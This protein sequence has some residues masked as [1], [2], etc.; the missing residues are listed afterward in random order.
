[1][2]GIWFATN[3]VSAVLPTE[4]ASQTT[5]SPAQIT[6]LLVV[7]QFVHACLFPLIGLFVDRYG[8][9]PFFIGSGCAVATICAGLFAFLAGGHR[10]GLVELFFVVLA[11]RLSGASMAR[12]LAALPVHAGRAAHRRRC[13]HRA[14]RL[15]RAGDEGHRPDRRSGGLG[16]LPDRGRRA[17]DRDLVAVQFRY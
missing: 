5:L 12:A 17:S 3:M 13:A 14:R 10:S 9:R 4:L 16:G 11:I 1:M 2:A 8:R 15:P 6:G 7:V